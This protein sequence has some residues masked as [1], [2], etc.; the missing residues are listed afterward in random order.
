M[1][2]FVHLKV[3]VE[4]YYSGAT[5]VDEVFLTPEMY[6]KMKEELGETFCVYELDG[7]HSQS[8]APIQMQVLTEKDLETF[9]FLSCPDGG[10]YDQCMDWLW[11][12]D[13]EKKA[14]ERIQSYV[15]S[16]NVVVEK[17]IRYKKEDEDKIQELLKDYIL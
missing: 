8:E 12:K 7:K 9:Q 4:A 13:T 14:F 5:H 10:L 16:F 2:E 11:G 1:R 3:E 15:E 17:T 6:D